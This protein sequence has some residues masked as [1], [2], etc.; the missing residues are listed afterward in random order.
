MHRPP[1]LLARGRFWVL[2]VLLVVLVAG[3]GVILHYVS[4]H[5]VLSV[6]VL[7]GA[8]ILLVIKHAGLLG[9]VYALFRRRRPRNGM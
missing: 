9:S 3:H 6:A 5:V 2:L 8:V 1:H 4:S 7:S